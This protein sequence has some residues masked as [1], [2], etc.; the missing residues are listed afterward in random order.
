MFLSLYC[1]FYSQFNFYFNA[2]RPRY[3]TFVSKQLLHKE[4]QGHNYD[5]FNMIS[6]FCIEDP[7]VLDHNVAYNF[8]TK[9]ILQTIELF[10]IVA[11][12]IT[13]TNCV[14]R[15]LGNKIRI[16]FEDI[17]YPPLNYFIHQLQMDKNEKTF[18]LRPTNKIFKVIDIP[19]IYQD[20]IYFLRNILTILLTDYLMLP[21]LVVV[22]GSKEKL[23]CYTNSDALK[24]LIDYNDLDL[25]RFE[26]R[27]TMENSLKFL[28]NIKN[29]IARDLKS[30]FD[31]LKHKDQRKIKE[32]DANDKKD[33]SKF[34]DGSWFIIELFYD[35]RNQFGCYKIYLNLK[36]SNPLMN[37]ILTVINFF[38]HLINRCEPTHFNDAYRDFFDRK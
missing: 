22:N 8:R 12:N 18:S 19:M 4:K 36:W 29:L 32:L 13:Y 34:D 11:R 20:M 16:R 37:L 2:I 7:F 23:H 33:A 21:N 5:G 1:R 35:R 28:E 9:S 17:L 25:K 15:L 10:N 38:L 14:D 27:N 3:G 6:Y 30:Q 24:I 31:S 26:N